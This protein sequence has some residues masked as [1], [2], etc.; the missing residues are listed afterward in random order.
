VTAAD[1]E[2][3]VDAIQWTSESQSDDHNDR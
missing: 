2:H 1:I 3:I